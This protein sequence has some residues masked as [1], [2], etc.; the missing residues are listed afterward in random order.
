MSPRVLPVNPAQV[1]K[2]TDVRFFF[3]CSERIISLTLPAT[4]FPLRSLCSL[5]VS[6]HFVQ[7]FCFSSKNAIPTKINEPMLFEQSQSLTVQ[8]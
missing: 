2:T 1:K 3:S 7:W 5:S 6:S 4:Q 8:D